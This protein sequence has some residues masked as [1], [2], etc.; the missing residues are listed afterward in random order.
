[1]LLF[2]EQQR[3]NIMLDLIE[4]TNLEV[5]YLM[6]LAF[7]M[8]FLACVVLVYTP[9]QTKLDTLRRVHEFLK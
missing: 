2:A 9:C 5:I 6:G 4:L 3:G 8:G 7:S 1:M